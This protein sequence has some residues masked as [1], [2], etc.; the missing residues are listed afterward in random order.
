MWRTIPNKKKMPTC[1]KR[2]RTDCAAPACKWASGKTR[3][4]CRSAKNYIHVGDGVYLPRTYKTKKGCAANSK[5]A[6]TSPCKWAS[7]K[8]RSFCRSEKNKK[9]K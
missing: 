3:S 7:G 6:C 4:F 8:K 5:S 2:S 9:G 1:R